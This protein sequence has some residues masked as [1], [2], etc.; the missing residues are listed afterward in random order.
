MEFLASGITGKLILY[1]ARA[2]KADAT[3]EKKADLY[4][5]KYRITYKRDRL[6]FNAGYDFTEKEWE[7]LCSP[8]PRNDLKT[9][10]D[11]LIKGL[12]RIEDAVNEILVGGGEYTHVKLK[13]ILSK[14]QVEYVEDAYKAQI[15]D[16]ERKG[17]VGTASIY[18]SALVHLK[19]YRENIKFTDV[20]PKWLDNYENHALKT[21]TTSTLSMY[22]RTLRT[23]FNLAIYEGS[24]PKSAYPF[25]Q[26]RHDKKFKIKQGSGTKVALTIE[27]LAEF[28]KYEP[29]NM[30][31]RRSKDLFMLSFY[32]GG[33]NIKDLLLLTWDMI[34]NQELIYTREK[35]K[36]TTDKELHIRIPLTADA[37]TIIN[38]WGNKDRSPHAHILPYMPKDAT[39]ETIRKVTLNQVRII[40]KH[41]YV[42]GDKLEIE[43]LSS[44]VSRHTYATLSKNAGVPIAYI[45]EVLGHQDVRTTENYLK[46]F[47][48]K[49][50]REQFSKAGDI[51]KKA[52]NKKRGAKNE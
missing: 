49:Q 23:L 32:L 40:N 2:K 9:T 10:K 19:A 35:T 26:S 47:E 5:V 29:E 24:I 44:M 46:R 48:T 18:N 17:Q 6:Y 13:R 34:K 7:K 21:I 16:L 12:R 33:I 8:R 37:L 27:Q 36:R 3:D 42:I 52:M 25:S 39:N 38:R 15:Y 50:R 45:K 14:G 11:I 4:P 1:T 22:L 43:G 41:L 28:A 20:T 30:A 31:A 51:L